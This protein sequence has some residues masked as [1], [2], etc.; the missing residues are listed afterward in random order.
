MHVNHKWKKVEL[1]VERS[2]NN[3]K[4]GGA[5]EDFKIFIVL[6]CL[7]ICLFTC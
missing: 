1:K 2:L 7:F 4:G 3:E 6:K 5:K